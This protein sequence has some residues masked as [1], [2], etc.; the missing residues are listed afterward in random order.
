MPSVAGNSKIAYTYRLQRSFV[1]AL[2]FYFHRELPE[3]SLENPSPAAVFIGPASLGSMMELGLKC[4]S[5]K[6]FPKVIACQDS[7][8][9]NRARGR[10]QPQ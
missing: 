2:N 4:P 1:Y 8:L 6:A 7:G 3:W 9:L 5:Y 10:G